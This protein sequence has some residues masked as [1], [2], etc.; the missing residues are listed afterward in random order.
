MANHLIYVR[1]EN[2]DKFLSIED[3]SK[4]I[5]EL[6]TK[7]FASLDNMSNEEREKKVK[8]LNILI[9]ADEELKSIDP[10]LDLLKEAK[11]I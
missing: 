5:N 4:F 11:K 9:K 3:K 8:I 10:Q 6:I 2:E 7:H 1:K